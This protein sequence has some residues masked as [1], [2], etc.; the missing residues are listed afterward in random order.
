[1]HGPLLGAVVAP[2]FRAEALTERLTGGMVALSEWATPL[3]T[4]SHP[5]NLGKYYYVISSQMVC[6]LLTHADSSSKYFY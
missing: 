6:K 5:P 2:P 4:Q 1:M 3:W